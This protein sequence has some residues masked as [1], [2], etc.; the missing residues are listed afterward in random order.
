MRFLWAIGGTEN[1]GNANPSKI[2]F[3]ETNYETADFKRTIALLLLLRQ[4]FKRA[5]VMHFDLNLSLKFNIFLFE[6]RLRKLLPS[7]IRTHNNCKITTVFISATV[8]FKPVENYVKFLFSLE[9]AYISTRVCVHK[10]CSY[11]IL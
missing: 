6:M 11:Y 2:I 5:I 10:T 8:K 9:T 1:G 4:T 3:T 7:E